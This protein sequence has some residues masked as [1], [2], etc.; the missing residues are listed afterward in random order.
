MAGVRLEECISPP[1]GSLVEMIGVS[2]SRGHTPQV[3][4]PVITHLVSRPTI[5]SLR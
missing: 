2:P 3:G 4:S 1:R 5:G